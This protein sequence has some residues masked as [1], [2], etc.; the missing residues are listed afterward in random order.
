MDAKNE[1]MIFDQVRKQ[2]SK[3]GTPQYFLITPKL[4]PGLVFTKEVALH[5][6]HNGPWQTTQEK[7]DQGNA[8][9]FH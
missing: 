1:A 3:K 9:Q 8:R 6:V 7:W 4:I 5:C 2:A